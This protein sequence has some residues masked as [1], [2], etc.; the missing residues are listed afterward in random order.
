[1]TELS[2]PM[3]LL[4]KMWSPNPVRKLLLPRHGQRF[5]ITL[6]AGDSGPLDARG[7]ASHRT[8]R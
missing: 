8:P 2:P 3:A 5:K 7:R 4:G 1:M 6:D